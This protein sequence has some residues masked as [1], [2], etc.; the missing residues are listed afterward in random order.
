VGGELFSRNVPGTTETLAR[1]R[2]GIAGCGGIGSNAAAALVRAGVGALILVDHD[3]VEESNLNRQ[4]FFRADMGEPK[5]EALAEHLRDINPAISLDV[6]V[7]QLSPANVA[8]VFA[9]A[10]ILIEAFD[11]A[12]GKQWLIERWCVAYPKR[13]IVCGNGLSGRGRLEDLVVRRVG[14]IHF[15]GDGRTDMSMGLCAPRVAIV[16]NMQ[17]SVAIDL[18]LDGRGLMRGGAKQRPGGAGHQPDGGDHAVDGGQ[19]RTP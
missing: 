10:Q 1:A 8:E 18:M 4:Y 3:V 17:A 12:D 9:D 11:R 2:I 6:R 7:M 16:A 5:A 19:G 15:C 14:M 13:P